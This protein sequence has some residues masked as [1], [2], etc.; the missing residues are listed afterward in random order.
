M[1]G[2]ISYN[3][4][5]FILFALPFKKK[6]HPALKAPHPRLQRMSE[7]QSAIPGLTTTTATGLRTS[8]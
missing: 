6:K 8:S 1:I 2:I 5:M 4:E 7:T 3:K